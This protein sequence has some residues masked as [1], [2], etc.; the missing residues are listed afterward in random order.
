MSESYRGTFRGGPKDGQTEP[1]DS[2]YTQ[3]LEIDGQLHRYEVES[4]DGYEVTF[5]WEGYADPAAPGAQIWT[6]VEPASA[7]GPRFDMGAS[8]ELAEVIAALEAAIKAGDLEQARE[9]V[10][11]LQDVRGT[12]DVLTDA[13]RNIARGLSARE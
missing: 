13:L 11:R 1:V 8:E 2:A 4:V 9:L 12:I 3:I 5:R 10:P 7:R 6:K